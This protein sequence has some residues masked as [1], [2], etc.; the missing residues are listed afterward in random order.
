MRNKQQN[1]DDK[2]TGQ[3]IHKPTSF[4]S[5]TTHNTMRE[6]L[7]GEKDLLTELRESIEPTDTVIDEMV[8]DWS[9][10]SGGRSQPPPYSVSS[11]QLS[12]Q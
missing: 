2:E 3:Q 10:A 5:S 8:A 4:E 12:K 9:T 6:A 11:W 1:N 7:P